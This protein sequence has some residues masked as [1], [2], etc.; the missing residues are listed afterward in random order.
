MTKESFKKE[1]KVFTALQVNRKNL[2]YTL[3]E[4]NH[5][6]TDKLPSIVGHNLQKTNEQTLENCF[7]TSIKYMVSTYY[8]RKKLLL[9][10]FHS[11][12]HKVDD[13]YN[14][15]F[16]FEKMYRRTMIDI[17]KGGLRGLVM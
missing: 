16:D 13:K 3:D 2:H 10:D 7:H 1:Q 15:V 11:D 17:M 6:T 4:L 14:F 5:W 9:I 12:H 8:F